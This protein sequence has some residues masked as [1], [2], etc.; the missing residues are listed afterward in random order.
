MN[1]PIQKE[2]TLALVTKLELN[3]CDASKYLDWLA[4]LMMLS[5][6]SSR[7]LNAEISP[8]G[9]TQWILE[10]RFYTPA[11]IDEWLN[12]SEHRKLMEELKS[13][14]DSK[15]VVISETI[16]SSYA[17]KGG[18]SVAVATRVKDG[19]EKAYFTHER[20]YQSAQARK[21]GYRGAYVQPP[22]SNT[23]G[24]WVTIIRFDSTQ[25]MNQWMTSDE[26]KKLMS[27][28]DS[29]VSST[30][31]RNVTT[32]FPGWFPTEAKP[33]EGPPNWKTALLILLGLYPS[34]MLVIKY[35]L[36]LMQ[37]YSP[38]LN[39]FIGNI[40]TVAFTT[41]VT[42][43]LFIKLYKSWLFPNEHT[44]TWINL[45][46]VLSILFFLALEVAVFWRFF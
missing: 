46:S 45:V 16:D 19:H 42:M 33:G 28:S 25:A 44:P 39:N 7:V 11:Q 9:A 12:S 15:K 34:V 30:D 10:Q 41:W 21:P 8:L 31:Y 13:D 6:E 22:T 43:P 20:K 2:T 18:I 35:F 40:M 1:A 17:F 37:G 23:P 14:V 27:E 4:R 26:R 29:L 36:P 32:S 5:V 38:A 3:S 24:V